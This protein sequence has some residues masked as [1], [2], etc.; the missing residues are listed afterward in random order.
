MEAERQVE[1][2]PTRPEDLTDAVSGRV[3]VGGVQWSKQGHVLVHVVYAA[4]A[5]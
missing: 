2:Y 5:P 1:S 3:A 4:T